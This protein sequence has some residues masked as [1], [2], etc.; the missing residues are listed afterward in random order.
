MKRLKK[1]YSFILEGI[2]YELIEVFGRD[3]V[4]AKTIINNRV[5]ITYIDFEDM[6]D[7]ELLGTWNEEIS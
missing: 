3:G 5:F 7:A 6:F 2:T 4:E 1:K